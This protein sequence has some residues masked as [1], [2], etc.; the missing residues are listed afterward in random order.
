MSVCHVSVNL[1]E[2]AVAVVDMGLDD[3]PLE[4][5]WSKPCVDDAAADLFDLNY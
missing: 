5:R 3:S 2:F 4:L 1:L